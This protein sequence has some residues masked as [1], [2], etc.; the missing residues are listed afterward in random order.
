MPRCATRFI[1]VPCS[2]SSRSRPG[3]ITR[4]ADHE[5]LPR[6]CGHLPR[7]IGVD[8]SPHPVNSR[9]RS[10]SVAVGAKRTLT[11]PPLTKICPAHSDT[12]L[13]KIKTQSQPH[14]SKRMHSTRT[15][16]MLVALLLPAPDVLAETA[17]EDRR[18]NQRGAC[19]EVSRAGDQGPPDEA[20]GQQ[21]WGLCTGAAGLFPRLHCQR[22]QYAGLTLPALRCTNLLRMAEGRAGLSGDLLPPSP[23]AENA[24]ARQDRSVVNQ[25]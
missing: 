17:R 4:R 3:A 23:P 2:S 21:K 24:T 15:L 14:I 19:E 13:A 6:S 22:R 7:A 16:T 25:S 10:T 8:W 20:G 12:A 1:S 11:E 5:M 18:S 9:Q